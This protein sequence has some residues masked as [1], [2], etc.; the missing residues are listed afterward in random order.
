MRIVLFLLFMC[1]H[2][3]AQLMTSDEIDSLANRTIKTFNVPGMAIAVIKDG[4]VIHSKGYGVK[5]IKSREPVDNKTL[6]GIA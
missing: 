3:L 4:A 1:S 2:L 6:F 5:S